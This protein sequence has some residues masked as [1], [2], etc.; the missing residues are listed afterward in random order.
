MK[1]VL[2]IA[3]Y[4]YL[5]YFSDGQKFIA[6]FYKYL[7]QQVQL[8]V[9]T[10]P[11]TDPALANYNVIPLLK[12]GFSRYM[13]RSLVKKLTRLIN[14]EGFET[15]IWEHPY[16]AWLATAVKKRTGI[17]TILH[18]HNIEYQRF[19][20]TGRWWWPFLRAYEKWA[21]RKADHLLF[22]T[23]EDMA[24]ATHKWKIPASGC[25]ELPFGVEWDSQPRDREQAS[26]ALRALHGIGPGET[27]LFFN[28]LLSYAPN[29]EA[30]RFIIDE[31]NP[32]LKTMP[33]FRYRILVSG[34]GLPAEMNNLSAYIPENISYTGF[35]EDIDLYFRGSD[36]LL[37][38]VQRGGGIKTK[39]VEAIA[40]GTTVIAGENGATGM[41]PA[42]CGN[43]LVVV[44]DQDPRL[45]AEAII[46]T[47]GKQELTPPQFYTFYYWENIIS[48]MLPV[49]TDHSAG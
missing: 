47:A 14:D 11:G 37:N 6:Q 5:P 39:M 18:T 15:V 44:A 3:P 45:F 46:K 25:S 41:D 13:D 27:I 34:K 33:G 22:I 40:A 29:L 31:V 28:G 7:S 26:A 49:L 17:R 48:R 20:S 43:K 10:V 12:A 8:T 35:V 23:P 32:V 4:P 16:Y 2:A 21:F 1:K 42:I 38:P 9:I 36:L 30:L 24:F 19:R